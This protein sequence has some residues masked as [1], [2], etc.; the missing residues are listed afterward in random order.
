MSAFQISNINQ[1]GVNQ[2]VAS[3]AVLNVSA[4]GATVPAQMFPWGVAQNPRPLA[5][6]GLGATGAGVNLDTPANFWNRL[7]SGSHG[8]AVPVVLDS[9]MIYNGATGSVVLTAKTGWVNN[10]GNVPAAGL[11][12]PTGSVYQL[13]MTFTSAT[14][15]ILGA[16]RL[17]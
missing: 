6:T 9:V 12:M 15:G 10:D 2:V 14:S 7:Y 17:A 5:L 8:Y 3:P 11:S 1:P 4:A 13:N 16:V